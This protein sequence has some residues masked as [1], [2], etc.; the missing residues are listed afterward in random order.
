MIWPQVTLG[1]EPGI[2]QKPHCRTQYS[3]HSAKQCC[4]EASKIFNILDKIV[5]KS[6]K[7]CNF[8]NALNFNFPHIMLGSTAGKIFNKKIFHFTLKI[9]VSSKIFEEF[10]IFEDLR[11]FFELTKILRI[12]LRSIFRNRRI[13]VFVFGPFSI[14]VATLAQSAIFADFF[15]SDIMPYM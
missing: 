12:R 15:C 5:W 10:S 3:C 6:L 7:M 9:F 8:L 11:R 13:F 14:F 4:N 2:N 1:W